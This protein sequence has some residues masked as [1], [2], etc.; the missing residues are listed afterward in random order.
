[1]AWFGGA[2]SGLAGP[3]MYYRLDDSGEPVPIPLYEEGR[4][5]HLER[6]FSD[7]RRILQQ[8]TIGDAKVSTVFVCINHQFGSGPPILF[9][10]MIFGGPLDQSQWRYSTREAALE[11]HKNVVQLVTLQRKGVLVGQEEE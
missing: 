2:G 8:D 1:M 4:H 11:G 7:R 5:H 6:C 3:A 9:E 10:T